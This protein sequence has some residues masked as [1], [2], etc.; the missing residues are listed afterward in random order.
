[1][2]TL[3]GISNPAEVTALLKQLSKDTDATVEGGRG[4]TTP[5]IANNGNQKDKNEF[6]DENGPIK[7]GTR[8]NGAASN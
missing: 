6:L 1:M 8:G 7:G 3:K 2:M 4:G 5:L